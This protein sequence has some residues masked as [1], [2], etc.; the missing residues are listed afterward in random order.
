MKS[1]VYDNGRN[2]LGSSREMKTE[3][4]A[5]NE[6]KIRD[7]FTNEGIIWKF[8]PP[9]GSHFGGVYERMI[10]SVRK[11]L[12]GLMHNQAGRLDDEAL[13]TLFCEV[14]AILNA[15]PITRSS[16][17]PND[18]QVLTPNHLLTLR[19][20]E[21]CPPGLF[22]KDDNYARRKWRQVQ[23]LA[24]IFWRRWVAEYI[25][26]LQERQKWHVRR[27]NLCVGDVVLMIDDAGRNCWS[28]A[29]VTGVESDSH[30]LVRVVKVRTAT[31]ELRRPVDKLCVLLEAEISE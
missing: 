20:P 10:R 18:M 4:E 15:R 22:S 8:N 5:W 24:D 27:R 7:E 16:A 26:M 17:D 31:T 23:Y 3:I 30:G 19:A 9:H 12:Y 13:T 29:R 2:L 14:E 6:S 21:T 11:V 1:I 28:L 25:P